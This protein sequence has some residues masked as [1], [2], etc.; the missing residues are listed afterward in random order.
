[1][2]TSKFNPTQI[3]KILK[4]FESGKDVD[5]ISREHGVSKA[6]FYKWRQRYGGME[7][8]ELKR[9]KALEEENAKL[10]RM[11]ADLAL[12]LDMAKY[13][14]EKKPLKPCHK[15]TIVTDLA[16]VY[17]NGKSKACRL[18]QTSRSSLSYLSVKNDTG[19]IER[20]EGFA[21]DHPREG[22]WKCY[23]RLRNGGDKVNHKRLHRVY[24]QLGL[25]LRRKVKKRLPAR[26]KE[27]IVIPESF[28]HTWSIDF[29][30][31]SLMGGRKFRSFNVI[32]DYNREVLFIE[33]DYSLKSRR[34]IW[35]LKHLTNRHGKPKRIRMDNGP[36]FV[37]KL[38]QEWSA[39]MDIE[40]KYTQPGKPTQNALI[41]RFNKTYREHVL[42]AHLFESI[43]EV[44]DISHQWVEDYNNHRPHDALGG[45]S[46]SAYRIKNNTVDGLRSA[47]ATPSLHSAH[48][49]LET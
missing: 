48:Q 27:A 19:L 34:I 29:M 5:T 13:I 7:A 46:P 49:L 20:L 16:C 33:T 32:D 6:T 9:L 43:D 4:E 23:Y 22:F 37:A 44:R 47:T 25:P 42:D 21:K 45:I 14:I 2:K 3:A 35:V 24:K 31:D 8:S 40:F 10:K 39:I 11:Y 12:E 30:S 18:L 38:A 28:T 17:P 26:V 41:E 36:E 15:R 1:M